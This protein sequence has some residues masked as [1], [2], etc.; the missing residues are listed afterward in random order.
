MSARMDLISSKPPFAGLMGIV[1]RIAL[2]KPGLLST[3]AACAVAS[4]VSAAPRGANDI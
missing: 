4:A 3:V 1:T 2:R